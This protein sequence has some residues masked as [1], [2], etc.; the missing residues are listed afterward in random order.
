MMCASESKCFRR[1][2]FMGVKGVKKGIFY[3]L[4]EIKY[5]LRLSVHKVCAPKILPVFIA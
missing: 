2:I 1:R 4:S 3:G 5:T